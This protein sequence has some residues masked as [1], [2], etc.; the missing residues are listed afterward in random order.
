MYSSKN[1]SN[2]FCL[3]WPL[4]AKLFIKASRSCLDE[5]FQF[6]GCCWPSLSN[7]M[8][9]FRFIAAFL[10]TLLLPSLS[11]KQLLNIIIDRQAS[12]DNFPLLGHCDGTD[13]I[14]VEVTESNG[15]KV[16]LY[17]SKYNV[18]GGIQSGPNLAN[19]A[20]ATCASIGLP[21]AYINSTTLKDALSNLMSWDLIVF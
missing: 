11:N 6:I 3:S 9:V 15:K 4:L 18:T 8:K 5:D 21:T 17:V 14:S 12:S 20:T 2:S 13:F 19:N 1:W 10:V 16:C 7:K